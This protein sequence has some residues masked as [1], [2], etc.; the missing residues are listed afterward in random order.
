MSLALAGLALEAPWVLWALVPLG[1]AALLALRGPLGEGGPRRG[2]ARIESGWARLLAVPGEVEAARALPRPWR[3]RL[4]LL[5]DVLL[6][7]GLVLGCFAL[8]LPVKATTREERELG[9]DLVLLMD[10]SPSMGARDMER[11]AP[12]G[13]R[14]RLE[15]AVEL[16]RDFVSRRGDD[17][18]ALVGFARHPEVIVPLT[19]DTAALDARLA[20]LTAV[21]A[22]GPEDATGIGGAVARAALLL[23]GEGP[24]DRVVLLLTDGEEN[25]AGPWAPREISPARSAALAHALGVRVHAVAI[26]RGT[27]GRDGRPQPLDT[28]AI[29]RLARHTGG[30][31][32][33]AEEA[34]T[35]ARVLETLDRL[36]RGE[37]LRQVGERLPLWR[38]TAALAL[39][40]WLLG[41]V[42]GARF[43]GRWP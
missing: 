12:G 5:P 8:A 24:R 3:V 30:E 17:R 36:E 9:L 25:V 18:I 1:L 40:F 19:D 11:F 29:E 21:A 37:V 23:G 14:T 20:R 10:L 34:R 16:A 39:L 38:P 13:G 43:F 27:P 2:P 35:L 15:I 32:F 7:A 26:G 33:E 4:S 6:C 42:C 22:E 31:L 41:R 28:N